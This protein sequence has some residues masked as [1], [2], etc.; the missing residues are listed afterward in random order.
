MQTINTYKDLCDKLKKG[1][2]EVRIHLGNGIHVYKNIYSKK[3]VYDL[4]QE[5]TIKFKSTKQFKAYWDKYLNKNTVE[6]LYFN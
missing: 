4:S 5:C 2:F 3:E 1:S 6:F